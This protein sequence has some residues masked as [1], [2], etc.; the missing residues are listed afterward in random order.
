MT[1]KPVHEL[2][3][4]DEDEFPLPPSNIEAEKEHEENKGM[5]HF[6]NNLLNEKLF[7]WLELRIVYSP[8]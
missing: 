1:R 6:V 7:N 5:K 4:L 8:T 2:P 3:K